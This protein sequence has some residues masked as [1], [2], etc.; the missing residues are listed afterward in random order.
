M[1]KDPIKL[2]TAFA[3]TVIPTAKRKSDATTIPIPNQSEPATDP[4]LGVFRM[5]NRNILD[6]EGDH[7]TTDGQH[8][9]DTKAHEGFFEGYKVP[10]Q[11]L[12][13]LG[14][15]EIPQKREQGDRSC[16]V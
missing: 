9:A 12:G 8:H 1:S 15:L 4:T 10:R 16:P 13:L 3:A 2:P 5:R 6:Q 7:T 11:T 14:D